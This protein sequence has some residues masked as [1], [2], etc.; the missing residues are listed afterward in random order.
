MH[1]ITVVT[2]NTVVKIKPCQGDKCINTLKKQLLLV[3]KTHAVA[4]L[5]FQNFSLWYAASDI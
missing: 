4:C 5:K 3:V 2:E 1:V